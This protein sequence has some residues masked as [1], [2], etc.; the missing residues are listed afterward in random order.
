MH[1]HIEYI[2]SHDGQDWFIEGF[3]TR[4]HG[5]N[6]KTIEDQISTAI[7][8]D[9]EFDNDA[10]IEVQ[11]RFDMDIIPRW[12]HQYQAHYFNYS[13]TVENTK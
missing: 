5:E 3:N 1:K 4:F 7:Q 12:L 8:Y 9:H 10:S 6:L 11:L 13:F 2:L